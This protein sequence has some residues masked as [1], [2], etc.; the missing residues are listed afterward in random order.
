MLSAFSSCRGSCSSVAGLNSPVAVKFVV[1]GHPASG[2]FCATA[3][4]ATSGLLKSG[5]TVIHEGRVST[6]P[7]RPIAAIIQRVFCM[8]R[9]M[10]F[11]YFLYG[12]YYSTAPHILLTTSAP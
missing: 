7:A 10:S 3:S 12:V 1:T 8:F 6:H 9:F 4:T 5:P 11:S 2:T